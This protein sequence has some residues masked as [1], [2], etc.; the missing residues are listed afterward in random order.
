ML[1]DGTKTVVANGLTST[2]CWGLAMDG[3]GNAYVTNQDGHN[4]ALVKVSPAGVKAQVTTGF[5]SARGVALDAAGNACV[6][7]AA[8]LLWRVYADGVKETVATS[9]GTGFNAA[10]AMAMDTEGN[11]VVGSNTGMDCGPCQ[12]SACR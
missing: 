11:A 10:F 12:V 6:A 4:G 2:E 9:I 5:G 1:A 3:D 7:N 8:G